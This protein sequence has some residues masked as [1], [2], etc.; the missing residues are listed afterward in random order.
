MSHVKETR[1]LSGTPS[2]PGAP[3]EAVSST[4]TLESRDPEQHWRRGLCQ[5]G[6][7][8]GM[9]RERPQGPGGPAGSAGGRGDGG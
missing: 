4:E 3:Q 6:V 8:E 7:R 1:A 5:G 9:V 2:L